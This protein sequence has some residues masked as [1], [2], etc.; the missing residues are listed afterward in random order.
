MFGSVAA[1][2]L[3]LVVVGGVVAVGGCCCCCCSVTED[4]DEALLASC[5][6]SKPASIGSPRGS[7]EKSKRS[8]KLTVL[9]TAMHQSQGLGEREKVTDGIA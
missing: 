2:T 1:S 8:S 3:M 6:A 7:G 5:L 9:I 4:E